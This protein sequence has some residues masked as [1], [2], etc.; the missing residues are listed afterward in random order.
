MSNADVYF[1]TEYRIG[2]GQQVVLS[3]DTPELGCW[4]EDFAIQAMPLEPLSEGVHLV[5]IKLPMNK[6]VKW[7]WAIADD[8]RCRNGIKGGE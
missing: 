4:H 7:K 6:P 1:K 5:I 8:G 3:G 2:E